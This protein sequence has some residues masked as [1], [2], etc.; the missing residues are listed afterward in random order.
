M[1]EVGE[2]IVGFA[3][4]DRARSSIWALFVEPDF[5]GRGIGRELLRLATDWLFSLGNDVVV[6]STDPGTRA[7]AFYRALGWRL[8]G[9]T[10][11]GEVA[12]ALPRT[13]G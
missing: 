6:L 8:Q 2:R 7:E 1:C 3:Y 11:D 12:L 10:S 4:A 13:G 9:T 5:E